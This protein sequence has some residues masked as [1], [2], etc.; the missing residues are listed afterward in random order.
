MRDTNLVDLFGEFWSGENATIPNHLYIDGKLHCT[1]D[2][3]KDMILAEIPPVIAMEIRLAGPRGNVDL[4][5]TDL[6]ATSI[7]DRDAYGFVDLARWVLV[8]IPRPVEITLENLF[9][10]ARGGV[11][12]GWLGYTPG[13]LSRV[14]LGQT[15]WDWYMF[16]HTLLDSIHVPYFQVELLR[17]FV[18]V[19]KVSH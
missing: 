7:P 5:P 11:V 6:I 4:P 16:L 8:R 3:L 19:H 1:E 14:S 9:P 13:H 18:N 17:P 2:V 10:M 12:V 15:Y